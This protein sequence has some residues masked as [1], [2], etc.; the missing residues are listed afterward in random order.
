MLLEGHLLLLD[1]LF[2]TPKNLLYHHVIAYVLTKLFSPVETV[3]LRCPWNVI[4]C[5]AVSSSSSFYFCFLLVFF[6]LLLIGICKYKSK[7]KDKLEVICLRKSVSHSP[8]LDTFIIIKF[9][10]IL[11]SHVF[12]I[13]VAIRFCI[14]SLNSEAFLVKS[15]LWPSEL[16]FLQSVLNI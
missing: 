10:Q 3:L 16:F 2:V 6:P 1:K 4:N 8:Y 7:T 13:K 9:H 12:V 15:H 5:L 11:N 14:F